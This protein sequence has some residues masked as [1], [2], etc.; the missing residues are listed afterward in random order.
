MEQEQFIHRL[1]SLRMDKGVSARDMSLSI[2]QSPGYMNNV[3]NGVNFP[4]MTVFFYICEYFG[5]TPKE[6]FDTDDVCPV[7]VRE[8]LEAA[9]KL[10]SEQIDHLIAIVRD[11]QRR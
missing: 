5:I 6:F 3:E 11:M 8:L 4:S 10:N 7:K 1:V 2:G 9:K